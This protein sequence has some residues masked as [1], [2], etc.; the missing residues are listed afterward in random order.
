MPMP[1]PAGSAAAVGPNGEPMLDPFTDPVTKENLK[2]WSD[3]VVLMVVR[4][5]PD[6]AADAGSETT[7]AAAPATAAP[8]GAAATPAPAAPVTP[9]ML[10]APAGGRP[11]LPPPAANNTLPPPAP[12]KR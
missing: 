5:D 7:G 4:V 11:S 3:V 1:M 9:P 6:Q 8:R 2:D 12:G 10:K